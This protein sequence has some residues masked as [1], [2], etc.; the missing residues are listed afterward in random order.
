MLLLLLMRY[1]L[2]ITYTG[3]LLKRIAH[4]SY[5]NTSDYISLGWRV[6]YYYFTTSNENELSSLMCQL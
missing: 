5:I 2:R 4:T 3:M 1:L 6:I